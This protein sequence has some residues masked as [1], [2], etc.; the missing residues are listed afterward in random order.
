[1]VPAPGRRAGELPLRVVEL[2]AGSLQKFS[3][4]VGG[5]LDY[6]GVLPAAFARR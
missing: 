3:A 6:E 4:G 1:M 2:E 5:I